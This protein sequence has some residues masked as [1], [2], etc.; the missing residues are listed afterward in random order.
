MRAA[1]FSIAFAVLCTVDAFASIEERPLVGFNPEA[2]Y[3]SVSGEHAFM[4]PRSSDFRGPC[5]GLNAMANHDYIPRN[6]FVSIEQ[7]VQGMGDAYGMRETW[8]FLEQLG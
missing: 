7:V 6:G 4:P 5:P 1:T 8:F 3:V 2:Q